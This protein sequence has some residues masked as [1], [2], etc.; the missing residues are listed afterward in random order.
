MTTPIPST[1]AA[2]VSPSPP[3]PTVARRSN[4]RATILAELGGE[5]T[6][7]QKSTGQTSAS[8]GSEEDAAI[9]QAQ[10]HPSKPVPPDQ[11][12][13]PKKQTPG[14]EAAPSVPNVVTGNVVIENIAVENGAAVLFPGDTSAP[15]GTAGVASKDSG[16]AAPAQKSP[17]VA[18]ASGLDTL[19]AREASRTAAAELSLPQGK[20]AE[21]VEPQALNS[22]T[23]EEMPG[24]E[25]GKA[26]TAPHQTV[27]AADT[28]GAAPTSAVLPQKEL[29]QDV[30]PVSKTLTPSVST[31]KSSSSGTS[32]ALETHLNK[33]PGSK[34]GLDAHANKV[35][36]PNQTPASVA[37]SNDNGSETQSG[38][39]T[40]QPGNPTESSQAISISSIVFTSDD[41]LRTTPNSNS[42]QPVRDTRVSTNSENSDRPPTPTRH[43]EGDKGTPPSPVPTSDTQHRLPEIKE[44][45]LSNSQTQTPSGSSATPFVQA[46]HSSAEARPGPTNTDSTLPRDSGMPHGIPEP[47]NPAM[48][49]MVREAH[50]VDNPKQTEIHI[51]LRTTTFGSIEVH[52]VIRDSQ[53]GLS[54]G[55]ERG[56]LRHLLSTEVPA[57]E[58]RLQ[59]HDLQLDSVRFIDQGPAFNAGTSSG[60]ASKEKPAEYTRNLHIADLGNESS[61]VVSADPDLLWTNSPG[62][63]VQA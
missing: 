48:P 30:A 10:S 58:G 12:G 45:S 33:V 14:A 28:Q 17:P 6:C 5:T 25:L 22:K 54:I 7:D 41:G 19:C 37:G 57:M 36:S 11:K 59:R 21:L 31:A 4:F 56:D 38:P 35:P 60:N 62:L 52:A 29:K 49:G 50:F 16:E 61:P 34:Q 24:T 23:A 51:D 42:Q 39:T 40:P 46:A 27:E 63:S 2:A 18:L 55:S 47:T 44:E 26:A 13:K 32:S 43:S 1:S 20:P 3:S 15:S 8:G 9:P 53:V